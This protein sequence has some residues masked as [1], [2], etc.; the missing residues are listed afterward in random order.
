MFGKVKTS[1]DVI[2]VSHFMR[3]VEDMD[4]ELKSAEEG[5]KL[6]WAYGGCDVSKHMDTSASVFGELLGYDDKCHMCQ[7]IHDV[8]DCGMTWVEEVTKKEVTI[9]QACQPKS[10]IYMRENGFMTWEEHED[11]ED[12][13][14]RCCVCGDRDND[15]EMFHAHGEQ[16][17]RDCYTE[18]LAED[19]ISM[20]GYCA[21][22]YDDD[23]DEWTMSENEYGEEIQLCQHC[24]KHWN[25]E[26]GRC[27]PKSKK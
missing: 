11:E 9:C 22:E 13:L 17:C 21:D 3:Q 25:P 19:G 16:M 27:E 26:T 14:V 5:E 24:Y 6:D 15:E 10:L 4:D 12:G 18:D 23:S 1:L 7:K 2:W 8:N 20:C